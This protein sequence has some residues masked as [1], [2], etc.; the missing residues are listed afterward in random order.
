MANELLTTK[1]LA[2]RLSV[3]PVTVQRWVR[4]GRIKAI[5]VSPKVQR[6]NLNEVIEAASASG[7]RR[8]ENR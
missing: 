4:E 7:V 3:H 1:E 8:T 2:K 6:F 5:H